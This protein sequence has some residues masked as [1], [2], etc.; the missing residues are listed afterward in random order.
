MIFDKS[1]SLGGLLVGYEQIRAADKPSESVRRAGGVPLQRETLGELVRTM[2]V[3]RRTC[4]PEDLISWE[5]TRHGVRVESEGRSH[6][7]G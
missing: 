1:Y 6:D 3:Q 5:P 7:A 2:V 4:R